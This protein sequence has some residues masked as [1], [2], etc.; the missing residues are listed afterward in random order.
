MSI[1]FG[2]AT[3]GLATTLFVPP[4]LSSSSHAM[5]HG[6]HIT[7]LV[8][9]GFTALSSTIFRS[10]KRGDGSRVSQEKLPHVG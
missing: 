3:A 2:V 9:G 1:S 6:I 8:L 4:R 7:L 5:I 10:L